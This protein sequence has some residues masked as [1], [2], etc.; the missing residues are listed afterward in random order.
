M[1]PCQQL[2]DYA[3]CRAVSPSE[4]RVANSPFGT[5]RM[6]ANALDGLIIL[7]EAVFWQTGVAFIFATHQVFNFAA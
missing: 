3:W 2:R 1:S 4:R 7:K 5:T 6:P